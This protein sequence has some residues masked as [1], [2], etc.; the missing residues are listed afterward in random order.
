M[1]CS[2]EPT[3]IIFNKPT[4]KKWNEINHPHF[5]ELYITKWISWTDMTAIE[6]KDNP[7]AE[8]TEGYLKKFEY[9]EAWSSFWRDTDEDNRKKFLTLPNFDAELFE[10]IT[11]VD[12]RVNNENAKKKEQ[13]LAKIEEL[14]QEAEKL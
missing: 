2:I 6:K 12:V 5:A 10:E 13:I 7:K 8:F 3:L 4:N 11:G 9:K 14:K 1:F